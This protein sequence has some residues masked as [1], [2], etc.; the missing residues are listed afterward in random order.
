MG[1]RTL[2]T[3]QSRFFVGYKKHTFRLWLQ[4][5]PRGVLL[6]PLVSWVAPANLGEGCLLRP[7]GAHCWRRWQWRPDFIVGDMGYIDAA[8]KRAVRERWQAAVITRLKENMN[9]VAPFETPTQACCRQGQ[10]LSWLGYEPSDQLHWF[11]VTETPALCAQCS[12]A[13]RCPRQF[14][15]APSVHETL[16]GLLPMNTAVSAQLL[17]QVRPWI[18]PAQ[19]YEKN[20]LG[21]SQVFF[22][23][24]RLAWMMSLLA[25]AAVLLRAHALLRQAPVADPLQEL[26]PQQ[27]SLEF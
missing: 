18:E 14:E 23:S 19:S 24:L 16:L 10:S 1:A 26:R 6:V 20:Q 12:E 25:D 9:L 3:G 5:Y 21:L 4:R 8:T 11:G 13:S 2:K 17:Q 7:S 27:L 15:F 22:N